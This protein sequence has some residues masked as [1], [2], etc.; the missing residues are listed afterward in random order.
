MAV[1]GWVLVTTAGTQLHDSLD[2]NVQCY[3]L[4]PNDALWHSPAHV[5][6]Q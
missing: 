2:M 6:H 5:F 1:L 3:Q 4:L